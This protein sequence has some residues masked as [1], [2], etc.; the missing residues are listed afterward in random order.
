MQVCANFA[1]ALLSLML[2]AG[3]SIWMAPAL[4]LPLLLGPLGAT[5]A[6]MFGL[7]DSAPAQPRCVLGG[8]FPAD[9]KLGPHGPPWM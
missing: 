2:A 9:D 4:S 8:P 5:A 3:I 7:L 1:G 6:T